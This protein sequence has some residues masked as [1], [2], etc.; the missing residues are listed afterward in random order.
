MGGAESHRVFRPSVRHDSTNQVG[1]HAAKHAAHI[2][3]IQVTNVAKLHPLLKA[4]WDALGADAHSRLTDRTMTASVPFWW[5]G[6]TPDDSEIY[7]NGTL[8]L[9]DTGDKV[10]GITAWH[11][12]NA[13]RVDLANRF[14]FVCQFGPVTVT[15]EALIIAED[16]RLELATFD[17]TSI[18]STLQ[19]FGWVAHRPRSWPPARPDVA[20]LVIYGGFPGRQRR[21]RG[22]A[23]TYPHNTVTGM[24]TEVTRQNVRVEVDYNRLFDANGIEGKIVGIDPGGSSGGPVYRIVDTTAG[25]DIE[26]I[27][28]I[29]ELSEVFTSMLGRHADVVEADGS[30]AN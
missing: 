14:R 29:Y 5:H 12:W 21:R 1:D 23:V 2:T 16:E 26:I 19:E 20:D 27:A 8:S 7:H 22:V 11:V 9:V 17:L 25:P 18:C 30:L 3:L 28:F 6:P 10:L 24:V 4:K 15:P 13:Y